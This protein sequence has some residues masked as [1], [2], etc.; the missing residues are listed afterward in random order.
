MRNAL[1]PLANTRRVRAVLD[2]TLLEPWRGWT[3]TLPLAHPVQQVWDLLDLAGVDRAAVADRMVVWRSFSA[4]EL[5]TASV[6]A[7]ER[8]DRTPADIDYIDGIPVMTPKVAIEEAMAGRLG[9]GLAE[10]AIATARDAS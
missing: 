5:K 4:G 9:G 2:R 8:G 6:S 1:V 7:Y 10:Q 3:T